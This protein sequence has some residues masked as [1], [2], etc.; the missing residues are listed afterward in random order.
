MQQPPPAVPRSVLDLPSEVL[1]LICA[2]LPCL[3]EMRLLMT[4]KRLAA[5]AAG[6]KEARRR[7]VS[8]AF[9]SLEAQASEN[10]AT[11]V[12]ELLEAQINENPAWD[13]HKEA[14]GT[15]TVYFTRDVHDVCSSEEYL[16]LVQKNDDFLR[17][18]VYATYT[19]R[20]G[21]TSRYYRNLRTVVYPHKGTL[22]FGRRPSNEREMGELVASL[23]D[24]MDEVASRT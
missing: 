5:R 20:W 8:D 1:S 7:A 15:P 11:D 3:P 13:R 22:R 24:T 17:A 9:E 4:T 19:R 23:C 18:F 16:I 2:V 21:S 6:A 10:P 12:F 14:E